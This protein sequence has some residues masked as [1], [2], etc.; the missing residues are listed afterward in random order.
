M[1]EYR[2]KV[3]KGYFNAHQQKENSHGTERLNIPRQ[4]DHLHRAG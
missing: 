1:E 3:L 4:I 2:E